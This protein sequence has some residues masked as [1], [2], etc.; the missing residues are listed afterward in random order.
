MGRSSGGS[1]TTF[2][3]SRLFYDISNLTHEGL[4]R[5]EAVR[6][7]KEAR[8]FLRWATPLPSR[9]EMVVFAGRG[10]NKDA[11]TA[12][13][14]TAPRR[15][16]SNGEDYAEQKLALAVSSN[17]GVEIAKIFFASIAYCLWC[18]RRAVAFPAISMGYHDPLQHKVHFEPK[19]AFE[20]IQL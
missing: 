16:R 5:H 4:H 13:A 19:S 8:R 14:S 15:A 7:L 6:V 11:T 17:V 12:R 18:A 10:S 20:E 1:A 2:P 9:V 3:T